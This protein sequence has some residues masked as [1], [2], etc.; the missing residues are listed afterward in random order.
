MPKWNDGYKHYHFIKMGY[1]IWNKWDPLEV[2]LLGNNYPPEFFDG[3]GTK[4]ESPLKRICEETLE[5]LEGYKKILQDFG[6]E[7][8]Q[9]PL[10]E[11][12]RFVDNPKRYPRGPLQPRDSGLVL[13]NKAYMVLGG[14]CIEETAF[15]EHPNIYQALNKYH[16]LE[17]TRELAYPTIM[18]REEYDHIAGDYYPAY[19]DFCKH[20]LDRK[21]FLPQVWDELVNRFRYTKDYIG[22][23]H[24]FPLG[25][26]LDCGYEG[27]HNIFT[28]E[29][30][31]ERYDLEKFSTINLLPLEGHTDGNYHPIK[32]GAILSL[33]DVQTYADTFPGWDVCYLPDQSFAKVRGFKKLKK[34]NKGK[35]WLAGEEDNDEFTYFVETWLQDWVGYV[36]ETVFDV[37][38]LVLD[39]HHVCVSNPNNEQVNTFLKKHNMEPV[40]VPWRHRYFWD[41]GLHCITLDLVRRGTQQEYFK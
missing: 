29:M 17:N 32:P 26:R 16:T 1:N 8:H 6:V 40:Y 31:R 22:S 12:E 19:E 33:F 39:E 28:E 18:T 11:Q 34:K 7:V 14:P 4:A 15:D 13:G 9:I 21:Y 3:L 24:C 41:G 27:T 35:W 36:E 23:A 38:V 37:N 25:T 2:C 10:P 5:D 30:L 20:R